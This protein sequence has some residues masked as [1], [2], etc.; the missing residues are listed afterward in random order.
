M[1]MN[2]DLDNKITQIDLPPRKYYV[3]SRAS[4]PERS[5]MWRDLRARGANIISSWIDEAGVGETGDFSELWTR[6]MAEI[7]H[8]DG[9]VL[10]LHPDDFPL[11]GALIET[12]MA[13]GMGK[14][15]H[16]YAK[17]VEM[18]GIT[19]RP[20]G[21]WIKHPSVRFI[22]DLEEFFGVEKNG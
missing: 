1:P 22:H 17:G 9:L 6:I 19:F 4:I 5:A 11:K 20:V 8:S 18:E 7:H 21:S 10:F 2:E 14:P 15:V 13:I 16:I 12:G 3:A